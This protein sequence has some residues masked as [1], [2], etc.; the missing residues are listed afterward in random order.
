MGTGAKITVNNA[1]H[2]GL[3]LLTL[4]FDDQASM[5]YFGKKDW[6]I[7]VL[8]D[9]EKTAFV[10]YAQAFSRGGCELLVGTVTGG[11]SGASKI[12]KAV[13]LIDTA[14]NVSS[15]GQGSWGMYDNGW[16]GRMDSRSLVAVQ[17]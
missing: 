3:S 6:E 1:A 5:Y 10:P 4:G 13:W 14:G 2:T 16:I 12:G 17:D 7:G 8:R 11:Y 9:D 15:V